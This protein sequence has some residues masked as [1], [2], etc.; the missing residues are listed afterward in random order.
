MKTTSKG[1]LL[2][3]AV[4]CLGLWGCA[5]NKAGSDTAAKLRELEARHAKLE[6]DYQ[7]VAA[8][9]DSIRKRL[10]VVEA[11][12]AGLAKKVAE[13]HAVVRERDELKRQVAVRTG[14]RDA[15]HTQM[16]QFGRDLQT[17]VGRV[18]AATSGSNRS[19][20]TSLADFKT[21]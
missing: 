14:E 8:A 5:Q 21:N 10:A 12:R 20:A 7:A 19:V 11:D 2:T 15:L 9:N 1:L 16:V 4:A 3:F 13:L 6:E 18:E 17:L